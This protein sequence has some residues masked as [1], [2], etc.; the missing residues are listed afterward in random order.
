[1]NQAVFERFLVG[2]DGTTDAEPTGAFGI[3][4]APDLFIRQSTKNPMDRTDS[5]KPSTAETHPG[6]PQRRTQA[7]FRRPGFECCLLGA[8]HET[9][10]KP[11][12]HPP[13]PYGSRHLVV[14]FDPSVHDCGGR[15]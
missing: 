4:L 5:T 13:R 10:F 15:K 8:P 1:M 14:R 9:A 11:G 7:R 6:G 2:D 12:Q 3:L